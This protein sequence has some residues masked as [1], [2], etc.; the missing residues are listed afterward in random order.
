MYSRRQF[1]NQ[2]LGGVCLVLGAGR[3]S[4]QTGRLMW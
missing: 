3:L 2:I 1:G 4:A